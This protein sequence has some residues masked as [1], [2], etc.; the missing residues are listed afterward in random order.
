M[1]RQYE[2]PLSGLSEPQPPAASHCSPGSQ[3]WR[4]CR[5]FVAPESDIRGCA[6][7]RISTLVH[8]LRLGTF[9]TLLLVKTY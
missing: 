7:G 8:T 6:I 2:G 1:I 9:V 5:P 3:S 4:R